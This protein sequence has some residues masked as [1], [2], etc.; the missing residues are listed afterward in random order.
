MI[1]LIVSLLVHKVGMLVPSEDHSWCM[2]NVWLLMRT[3]FGYDHLFPESANHHLRAKSRQGT[4]FCIS[5]QGTSLYR[6]RDKNGLTFLNGRRKTKIE[7]YFVTHE[8]NRKFKFQCPQITFCLS[9]VTVI[10]LCVIYGCFCI[11]VADMSTCGRN[12]KAW[13]IYYL[14]F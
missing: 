1:L 9:T 5:C 6:L 14:F 4:G 12:H 11:S 13:K 10:C 7:E 3:H 2:Q 8:D